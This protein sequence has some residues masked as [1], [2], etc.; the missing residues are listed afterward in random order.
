MRFLLRLKKIATMKYAVEV[1]TAKGDVDNGR[2]DGLIAAGT[3]KFDPKGNGEIEASSAITGIKGLEDEL[4]FKWEDEGESLAGPNNIQINWNKLQMYD[5]NQLINI[6]SDGKKGGTL[7]STSIDDKGNLTGH[8]TNGDQKKLAAIPVAIFKDPLKLENEFGT[9]FS[10]TAESG[11]PSFKVA[12]LNGAGK[13]V[14]GSLEGANVNETKSM[15][16]LMKQQ[17]FYSYNAKSYGMMNN[18][19]DVLLGVIRV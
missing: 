16:D 11:K 15:T 9:I 18:M 17:R 4:E 5:N 13:I 1:Y 12:N 2:D 8:Y 10:D 6:D 3:I 7:Q 19:E 14:S